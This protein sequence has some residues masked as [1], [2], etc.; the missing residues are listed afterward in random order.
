MSGGAFNYINMFDFIDVI[1]EAISNNFHGDKNN[2]YSDEIIDI[3]IDIKKELEI[4]DK[5]LHLIDYLLEV[6]DSEET[7]IKKWKEIK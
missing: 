6:D 2:Q 3:L 7:F 1:Q 4:M 5:K